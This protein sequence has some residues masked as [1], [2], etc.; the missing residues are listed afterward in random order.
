[1]N[2][3]SGPGASTPVQS[4]TNPTEAREWCDLAV[5]KLATGDADGAASAADAALLVL[6]RSGRAVRTHGLVALHRKQWQAA[7]AANR[8]A[9]E[10]DGRDREAANNLAIALAAQRRNDEARMVIAMA[11]SLSSGTNDARVVFRN[12]ALLEGRSWVVSRRLSRI[13]IG[14]FPAVVFFGFFV[15]LALFASPLFVAVFGCGV[16]LLVG[17]ALR[18]RLVRLVRR[19]RRA[20]R[21]LPVA[22]GVTVLR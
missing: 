1:M 10:L 16:A 22:S 20:Y 3:G 7:E 18:R 11:H 15:I 19:E 9:L 8:T 2:P 21:A 14:A 17:V 5:A 13:A 12:R 4:A 6:P